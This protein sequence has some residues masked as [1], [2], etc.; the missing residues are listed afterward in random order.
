MYFFQQSFT[1]F[2]LVLLIQF[3]TDLEITRQV[4]FFIYY[5]GQICN[6]EVEVVFVEAQSVEL[7]FNRTIQLREL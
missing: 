6:M 3:L 4:K 7:A 2:F 5:N 1:Y